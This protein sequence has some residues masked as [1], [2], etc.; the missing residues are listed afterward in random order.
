MAFSD[1][2]PEIWNAQ[3]LLDFRE[4]AQAATL[5]NRQY[6]GDAR[7]GNTVNITSAV[8][9]S[10]KDYAGNNRQ[11]SADAVDVSKQQLLIDQEKNFDFLIDDIDR[12]QA[13]GSM[14]A[15][16]ESAGLGIAEDADQFL[17]NLAHGG[18]TTA[19]DGS[20][21]PPSTAEDAWDIL[22]DL[23]K[24]L[25][26]L[27]VPRSNR[28]AFVNSEFARHLVGNDSKLTSV[29]T[30]GDSVGLREGTLGKV[31]GFRIIESENLPETTDEQVVAFYAPSVAFV[32]QVNDT[33]ALRDVDSFS[34]RLRGLHVYGGKVVRAD[35]VA[36]WDVSASS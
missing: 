2:I 34:D 35:G 22:A 14:D 5:V 12:A 20:G 21:T 1:F 9:V 7:I 31:L 10:I 32:S 25:N 4:Q 6:E 17:L 3:L 23:R 11:T 29:D 28:V 8:D 13:A 24:A 36:T 33:E 30:S 27:H 19:Q 18:A 15:Y 26:K 16:T